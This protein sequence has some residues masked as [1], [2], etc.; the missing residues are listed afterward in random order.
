[1]RNPVIHRN[2]MIVPTIPKNTTIAKFS[3]NSDFLKLYPAE[4]IIGGKIIVKKISLLNEIYWLRAYLEM[5][6]V[7]MPMRIAIEDSWT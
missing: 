5:A 3:K 2:P 1:M 7:I 4:N 6:A